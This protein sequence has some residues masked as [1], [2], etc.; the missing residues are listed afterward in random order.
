MI[1]TCRQMQQCEEAAFARNVNAAALM[2]EAGRGIANVVRQFAPRP[3]SLVLFLGKGNNAGDAL[4]AAR[5]LIVEGWKL[6]A[7]LCCAPEAM[8]ELPHEHFAALGGQL[9]VIEDA[10]T[11]D[12]PAGPLVSLDG[13]LGIGAQ[14]PMKPELQVLA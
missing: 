14:G 11:F 9:R 2:E 8:K 10:T 1:T 13:L 5:K 3:G 12:F 6:H 7:R 4:V